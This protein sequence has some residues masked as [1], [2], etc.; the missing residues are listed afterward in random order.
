MT[1]VAM[2]S[3]VEVLGEQGDRTCKPV[4]DLCAGDW[5]C[6]PHGGRA[7]V[8]GL[9]VVRRKTRV[10]TLCTVFGLRAHPKQQ[11][12][13]G[14]NV[15]TAIGN[16]SDA[17]LQ[18]CAGLVAILL[19]GSDA[20]IVDGVSCKAVNTNEACHTPIHKD[21]AVALCNV[22]VRCGSKVYIVRES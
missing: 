19:I 6:I 12:C 5:V 2:G 3:L 21:S 10:A 16:H 9:V 20:V 4:E 22:R 8:Y 18:P 1:S 13:F 14:N 11:I 17:T 15:W 7:Q